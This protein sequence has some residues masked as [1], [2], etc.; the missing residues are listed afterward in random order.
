MIENGTVEQ[1]LG[2]DMTN[3]NAANRRG[4]RTVTGALRSDGDSATD[5]DILSPEKKI[6]YLVEIT[7]RTVLSGANDELHSVTVLS[8]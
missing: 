7:I 5:K 1:L 8:K 4:V 6:F 2:T 3:G